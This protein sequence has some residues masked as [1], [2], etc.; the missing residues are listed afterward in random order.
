LAGAAL[1]S[2]FD[3]DRKIFTADSLFHS[4]PGASIGLNGAGSSAAAILVAF[5]RYRAW[6]IRTFLQRAT[7]NNAPFTFGGL[8]SDQGSLELT[9]DYIRLR[10]YRLYEQRGRQDG[11]DVE[12]WLL[13]ETEVFGKKASTSE[14]KKK[15]TGLPGAD[16]AA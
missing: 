8:A 3:T 10:A 15:K 1:A 9:E 2:R 5:E 12:D 4:F 14:N 11:H 13:A 6:S 7:M 16:S